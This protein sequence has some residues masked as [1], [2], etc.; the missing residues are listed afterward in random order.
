MENGVLTWFCVFFGVLAFAWTLENVLHK[1]MADG[2]GMEK[3]VEDC[4]E[5]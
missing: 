4:M 5:I 3:M 2:Q 1:C